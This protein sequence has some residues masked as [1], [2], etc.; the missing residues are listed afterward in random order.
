[1][2]RN[3]TVISK[4]GQIAAS[5][6]GIGVWSTNRLIK[7]SKKRIYTDKINTK[8]TYS[9]HNKKQNKNTYVKH[10][11]NNQVKKKLTHKQTCYLPTNHIINPH[12]YTT[13]PSHTFE[14][15]PYY[16]TNQKFQSSKYS[17]YKTFGDPFDQKEDGNIRI[18]SQ[19]IDCLGIK[20]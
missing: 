8:S 18:V 7:R 4:M 12:K 16:P 15:T 13:T 11:T 14:I 20:A 2:I 3:D 6:G 9:K 10:K 1:M 19:N 5:P 17:K